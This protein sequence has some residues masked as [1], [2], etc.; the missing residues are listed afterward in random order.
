M[1]DA[2]ES[3]AKANNEQNITEMMDEHHRVVDLIN[4]RRRVMHSTNI[5]RFKLEKSILADT[6]KLLNGAAD[7]KRSLEFME[8]IEKDVLSG[9]TTYTPSTTANK[10]LHWSIIMGLVTQIIEPLAGAT[11]T[12]FAQT[13][14]NTMK[15][16][17]KIKTVEDINSANTRE[18]LHQLTEAHIKNNITSVRVADVVEQSIKISASEPI[19]PKTETIPQV[20]P[21]TESVPKTDTNQLAE[22]IPQVLPEIKFT[23]AEYNELFT[24]SAPS[25]AM[26]AASLLGDIPAK[27]DDYEDSTLYDC[28]GSPVSKGCMCV[29]FTETPDAAPANKSTA[30][31]IFE[32]DFADDLQYH[33]RNIPVSMLPS[34]PCIECG[35]VFCSHSANPD[36]NMKQLF[37]LLAHM[38]HGHHQ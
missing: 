35:K 38:G 22:P 4:E 10:I 29:K 36:P 1:S 34:S 31:D 3:L 28:C 5:N 14:E 8:S 11:T 15:L 16:I 23:E 18:L 27:P 12:T 37:Y 32:G 19:V 26:T 2:S 9:D 30:S 7:T 33:L 25:N 24:R 6:T 20:I 13:Y 21:K 17:D